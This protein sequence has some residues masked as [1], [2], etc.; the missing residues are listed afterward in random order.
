MSQ[1]NQPEKKSKCK[2]AKSKLVVY[3]LL[4]LIL[5]LTLFSVYFS[6][7]T[8]KMLNDI[9]S[10][11]QAGAAHAASA[12]NNSI[13]KKYAKDNTLAKAL[14]AEKPVVAFFYTDWCGYCQRFAPVFYK[15]T[16]NIKS[17]ISVAY[18][19]CEFSENAKFIKEY[20]IKA[21]PTVYLIDPKTDVKV[22]VDN[23]ELFASTAEKDL[24]DK[25]LKF[26][27]NK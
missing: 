11:N 5:I 10:G 21:F 7:T 18:I 25:F 22:Q 15:I 14:K 23:S 2:C 1:E 8:N 6:Y 9:I 26:A 17:N 16:K 20:G 19:N 4:S 12:S 3:I 13:T 27:E 24:T